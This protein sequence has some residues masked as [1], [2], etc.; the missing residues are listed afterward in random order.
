M[1]TAAKKTYDLKIEKTLKAL[2]KNNIKASY[3]ETREEAVR[4]V[5]DML[6]EGDVISCGGTV[7]LAEA[8]VTA[9]M[10]SGKYTFLD[11][12]RVEDSMEVYSKLATC[13][14]FLTSANAVTEDGELYN[15]DGNANR[16]SAIAFGP[17]KVIVVA[18]KNKLVRNMEEAIYRVK[19]VAAP[20]NGMRLNKETPCAKTGRCI[21]VDGKMTDGC[22]SPDRMCCHYAVTGRQRVERI[23]VIIVGEE[24]GY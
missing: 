3:A 8:G 4:L 12:A 10:N 19:T 7:T 2:E 1:D 6:K 14:A 23:Y 15:V 20:A 24:L 9:L 13:D 16:I 21:G 17:K 5:E 11:R 18:G 22:E